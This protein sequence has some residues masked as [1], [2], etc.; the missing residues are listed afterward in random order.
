MS[1]HFGDVD[2]QHVITLRPEIVRAEWSRAR[3]WNG[4]AIELRVETRWVPDST[5]LHI[6]FFANEGRRDAIEQLR[7]LAIRGNRCVVRHVIDWSYRHLE[8]VPRHAQV[9]FH[10]EASIP[11]FDLHQRSPALYVDLV[12][13]VHSS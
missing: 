5:E 9:R 7:G 1:K 4:E 12:D 2:R 10:F 3:S 8:G 11:R 13:Y 6:D